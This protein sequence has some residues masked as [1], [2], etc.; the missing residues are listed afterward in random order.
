[1]HKKAKN[2]IVIAA[3]L[4]AAAATAVILLGKITQKPVDQQAQDNANKNKVESKYMQLQY[5][6][7]I[8]DVLIHEQDVFD[9]RITDAFYMRHGEHD[10]PLYRIDFGDKHAGKWLGMLKTENGDICVTT[11]VFLIEDEELEGMSEEDRLMYRSCMNSYSYMVEQIM[12]DSDFTQEKPID[13]DE[14]VEM[15]TKYWSLTLPGNML[16]EETCVDDTYTATFY[17]EV[18]GEYTKMYQ[19][20]IG[21]HDADFQL[22]YYKVDNAYKAISVSSG[23]FVEQPYWTEDDYATAYRMMDTINHVIETIM[24]SKQ[25]SADAE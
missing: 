5:P 3:V 10:I 4:V 19:V 16:V 6:E 2:I 8:S 17:G 21:E 15:K 20:Y 1:M 13:I 24:Q 25:F 12:S 18:D 23:E 14:E 7:D 11:M 22:G 9:G